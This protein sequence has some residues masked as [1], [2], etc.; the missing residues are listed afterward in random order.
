MNNLT[1][2]QRVQQ[3]A[4]E[5][6]SNCGLV[7]NSHNLNTIFIPC[8]KIA[9]KHESQSVRQTLYEHSIPNRTAYLNKKGLIP[10]TEREA[11]S[12]GE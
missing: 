6:Q 9:L 4:K 10:D 11:A 8:A 1:Y 3:L 2:E 12:D 5:M 7:V